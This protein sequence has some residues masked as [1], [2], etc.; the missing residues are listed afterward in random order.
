[1]A[2]P[3]VSKLIR[4]AFLSRVADTPAGLFLLLQRTLKGRRVTQEIVKVA[5]VVRARR[6]A[7]TRV[8]LLRGFLSIS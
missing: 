6:C 2:L 8:V 5:R 4:L 1:M 7:P 3:T